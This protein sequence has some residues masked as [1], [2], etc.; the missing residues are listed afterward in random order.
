M[1]TTKKRVVSGMR[2]TGEIHL[3][4][5]FGVL[6]N[7]IY[8]VNHFECF[9]FSADWHALTSEYKDPSQIKHF[10]RRNI[11]DWLSVGLNPERAVIFIQ[12]HVK[13]H[14]ELYLL[15]SMITPLGWLERNPTYKE[16]L[17][18]VQG[19]DL[20]MVGFLGYPVLQAADILVYGGDVVPVGEDQVPHIELAREIARRFNF[21]YG[22]VLKEPQA[23]LT[24]AAKLPGTDG[25]KMSNSYGNAIFLSDT[26]EVLSQKIMTM[27]TDPARIRREN[28][29]NPDLCPLFDLHEVFTEEVKRKEL[30]EGCRTAG[31]GCIDCK[32]EL[33][34]RVLPWHEAYFEKKS[35][36]EAHPKVV[37]EILNAGTKRA[38]TEA[39]KTMEKVREAIHI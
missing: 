23:D 12:S 21:F 30:G 14:A 3:G 22:N 9:F 32:K 18:Q 35:Y 27:M 20:S 2:A 8:L 6:K 16:Q 4:H 31:I 5:Y 28:P 26:K 25:R 33:L 24:P 13:E 15:L 34:K 37:D 39:E 1:A 10:V 19:R 17:K 7:W 36:Y 29:G 38:Q 11:I